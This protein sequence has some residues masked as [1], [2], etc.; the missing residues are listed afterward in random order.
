MFCNDAR[1]ACACWDVL[2]AAISVGLCQVSSA[3]RPA[4][5]LEQ[6]HAFARGTSLGDG[7]D[8]AVGLLSNPAAL[9]PALVRLSGLGAPLCYMILLRICKL[10]RARFVSASAEAVAAALA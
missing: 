8:I 2:V 9:R 4:H 10:A 5:E 6:T 1:T 3:L 7:N